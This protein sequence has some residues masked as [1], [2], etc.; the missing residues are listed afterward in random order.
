MYIIDIWINIIYVYIYIIYLYII[1]IYEWVRNVKIGCFLAQHSKCLKWR[2]QVI[3][4][5]CEVV[6]FYTWHKAS[7][8]Q[9]FRKILM[10]MNLKFWKSP[11]KDSRWPPKNLSIWTAQQKKLTSLKKKGHIIPNSQAVFQRPSRFGIHQ[12]TWNHLVIFSDDSLGVGP[13]D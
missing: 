7:N 9:T 13:C 12:S 3:F 8:G 5:N 1:I 6:R 2:I 10:Q 4:C 11:W